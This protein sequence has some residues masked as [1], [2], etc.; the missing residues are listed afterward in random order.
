MAFAFSSSAQERISLADY[1]I[2]ATMD[3]KGLELYKMDSTLKSPDAQNIVSVEFDGFKKLTVLLLKKGK[4]AS[5]ELQTISN[6]IKQKK[7]KIAYQ[8]KNALISEQ[9]GTYKVFYATV[10]NGNQYFIQSSMCSS[11]E[12]AKELL[13]TAR[14]LQ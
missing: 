2:N 4:V 1:G 3:S 10:L 9:K 7:L 8:E 11:L 14:S 13:A 5:K 6:T 12:A